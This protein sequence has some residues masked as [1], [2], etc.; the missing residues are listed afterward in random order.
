MTTVVARR[1]TSIPPLKMRWPSGIAATALTASVCPA[2]VLTRLLLATLHTLTR[3]SS[4]P[5]MMCWPSGV[6]A[7]AST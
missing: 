7:T 5:L 1:T 2:Q 4:E 6:T 3:L